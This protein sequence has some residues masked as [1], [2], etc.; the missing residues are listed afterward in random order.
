MSML[1][2]IT[3]TAQVNY[4]LHQQANAKLQ[5]DKAFNID[6]AKKAAEDFEAFFITST[7]ESMFA[8]V[9]TDGLMG[10]GMAEKI[11]R[12]MMFN[13]YGKLMAKNGGI[14]VSDQVMA[15]ILAMQEINSQGYIT[16]K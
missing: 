12:S 10:G 2:N 7:L 9:K 3:D 16:A 4:A 1:G 13:E 5:A 8:G 14:G 11:Y 6:E 15:S